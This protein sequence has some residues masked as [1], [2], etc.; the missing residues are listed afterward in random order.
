[1]KIGI[2]YSPKRA[3]TEPLSE[4]EHLEIG[5]SILKKMDDTEKAAI[6]QAAKE[7]RTTKFLIR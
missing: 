5:C 4:A 6:F 2:C 7:Q 1:M 3:L